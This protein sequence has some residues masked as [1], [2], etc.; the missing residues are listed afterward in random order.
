MNNEIK[1]IL[2]NFKIY[3]D[4]YKKCNETQFIIF[5]RDIH[6][7]LD[8]ITNLQE[9]N[10]ILKKD[11]KCLKNYYDELLKMFENRLDG[12]LDLKSKIDK[13]IILLT[14]L[15]EKIINDY[16]IVKDIDLDNIMKELG[17]N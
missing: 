13:S 17:D 4:R 1:E 8:Y 11:V 6:L 16:Y 2:D 15:Q 9:E 12:Y 5:Y 7:L 14:R 10:K 3:E